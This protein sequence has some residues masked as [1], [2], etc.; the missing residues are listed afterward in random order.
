M[1]AQPPAAELAANNPHVGL[2]I[3]RSLGF[4]M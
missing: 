4:D 1:V 2:P 3:G